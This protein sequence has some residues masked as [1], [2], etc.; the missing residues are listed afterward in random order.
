MAL[1]HSEFAIFIQTNRG[2]ERRGLWLLELH[3]PS[4]SKKEQD[5]G[6]R[7]VVF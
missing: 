1:L 4:L 6:E 3:I 7:E 2:E 5:C